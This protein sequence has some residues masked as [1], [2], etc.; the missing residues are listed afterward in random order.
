MVPRNPDALIIGGGL[1]GITI[2]YELSQLGLKVILLEA[3]EICGGT[4]RACAGRAQ[5]VESEN[6][7]YLDLVLSG[8]ERLESLGEEIGCDLELETPGHLTLI[9]DEREWEACEKQVA[10]LVEK[11]VEA[12]M[13]DKQTLQAIEPALNTDPFVGAAYSLERR[14]NPFK[15]CFGLVRAARRNGVE[16]LTQS[17]VV[18]FEKSGSCLTGIRT[19]HDIFSAGVV[20][21]AGGAWTNNLLD[22]AGISIPLRFTQAEAAV[23]EPLHPLIKHHIGLAGFYDIVHGQ[24]KRVAF[25]VGQ[26]KNG[27]LFISNAIQSAEVIN[28]RSTSWGLPAIIK[29]L[30]DLFPNTAKA[31]VM[32]TWSAPSPFM[33]DNM[34]AIGWISAYDNLF[35][36]AG[37]HL[38]IS[39]IPILSQHIA[40]VVSGDQ[41]GGESPV[42]LGHILTAHGYTR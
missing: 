20:I 38:A 4:T 30:Q 22:M 16:I 12:A 37:F 41:I 10:R 28:R 21:V 6:E 27:N 32:R 2:A 14:L 33:P 19:S 13:L 1:A 18:G 9:R 15:L 23:S 5:V 40:R 25:G 35:V 7:A 26:H 42:H 34:P 17:P 11:N 3:K 24:Q 31:R 29:Y 8:L 39:T 36:A